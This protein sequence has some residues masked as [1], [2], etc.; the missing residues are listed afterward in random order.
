[1]RRCLVVGFGEVGSAHA[2]I[3]ARVPSREVRAVDIVPEKVPEAFRLKDDNY[4]PDVLLLAM[5][6]SE[7][8]VANAKTY[9]EKYK[10]QMVNVLSTVPPGTCAKIGPFVTHSTTRGLH[11]H[12][13]D[14]ILTMVKHVGGETADQ[15]ARF[16]GVAGI[17][18]FTHRLA[19]TTEAAHILN[20]V[21]YGVNLMLAD[22]MQ[23]MCRE[24]GVDYFQAV[25]GYTATNNDGFSALDQATKV[26][27]ILTPPGG[28]IGGHCVRQSA[29]LIP[30]GQRPPVIDML[31]KYGG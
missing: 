28:K 27:M 16:Y 24:W 19:K 8:Y 4:Q 7:D 21:A 29:G 20:N 12:L 30:E 23:K 26:R 1:M 25:M 2:N 22:E 18:C 6:N 15:M 11:P 5:R 14:G 3:I 13:E 17:R 10:P 9:I 31:A